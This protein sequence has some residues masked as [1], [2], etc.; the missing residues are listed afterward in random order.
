MD[1]H[2]LTLLKREYPEVRGT[3]LRHR[4]PVELLVATI[5]SAQTTDVQVNKVTEKL[6]KKY[7]SAEDYAGADLEELRNDIR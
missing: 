4:N 7:R 5:L 3:A 2:I 6:F 1:A